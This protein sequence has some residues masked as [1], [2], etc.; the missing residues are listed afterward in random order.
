MKYR[1]VCPNCGVKISRVMF[2][3]GPSLPHRCKEC[4]CRYRSHAVWEWVADFIFAGAIVL[5][6]YLGWR[7]H[8]SWTLVVILMLLV[9]LIAYALFPFITPF[10]IV[11][12][13]P[14]EEKR[15]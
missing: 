8:I 14:E 13:K 1:A 6:W 2:F 7:H 15:P 10:V 12:K 5:L 9:L 11:G 3:L 4:N